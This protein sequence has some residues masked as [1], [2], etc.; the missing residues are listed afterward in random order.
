MNT[1]K[2]IRW[3][4]RF[5]SFKKAMDNLLE[6]IE[7]ATIRELN[8]FEK[9]GLIQAFEYNYELAWKTVKDFYEAQGETDIQGSRDAFTLAFNRGLVKNCGT[10]LIESIRSRQLSSHTYNEETAE[11]VYN[12]VINKY[13]DAFKEL[14]DS[15][16]KEMNKIIE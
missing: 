12:D 10:A 14:F 16:S 9:Q 6:V 8:K 2:E 15:L 4:Q 3:K 7:I 11:E 5:N 13:Y 1:N